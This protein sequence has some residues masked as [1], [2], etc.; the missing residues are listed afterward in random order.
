MGFVTCILT[1]GRT[2][3]AEAVERAAGSVAVNPLPITLAFAK[4]GYVT[5]LVERSDGRR[6]CNLDSEV[7]AQA[8]AITPNWGVLK[9]V[10]PN[11]VERALS[12]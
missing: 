7:K 12:L 4:P 5:A 11:E 8:G 10:N 3:A 6:V 1:L 9:L 2:L